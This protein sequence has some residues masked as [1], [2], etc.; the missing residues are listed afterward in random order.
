[1]TVHSRHCERRGLFVLRGRSDPVRIIVQELA[2]RIEVSR[3]EC[4]KELT[5]QLGIGWI[6]SG[7]LRVAVNRLDLAQEFGPVSATVFTCQPM[8]G[9]G[10]LEARLLLHQAFGLLLEVLNRRV[11]RKRARSGIGN[12]GVR[13]RRHR[14]TLSDGPGVRCQRA[15]KG[16][17][18]NARWI[19][20][21]SPSRGQDAPESTFPKTLDLGRSIVKE[22]VRSR[23]ASPQID[24]KTVGPDVENLSSLRLSP[25]GV[26]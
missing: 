17:G 13:R 16:S 2:D 15:G 25:P 12:R 22:I 26:R 24:R 21:L 5:G 20:G 3:I 4:G 6:E 11:R 7:A 8:L 18:E 23:L 19:G 14:Q 9:C 10:K 1:M